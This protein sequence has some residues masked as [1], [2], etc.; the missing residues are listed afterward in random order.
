[1]PMPT[2]TYTDEANEAWETTITRM[3]G[4]LAGLV[5]EPGGEPREVILA[6]TDRDTDGMAMV[7]FREH[8]EKAP[9]PF[10]V[11][12]VQSIPAEELVDLVVY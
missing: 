11:G 8:D 7:L 1:M 6:G 10:A 3:S 12:P 4:W 2:I 5:T 9:P